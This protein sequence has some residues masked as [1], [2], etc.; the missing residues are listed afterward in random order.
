MGIKKVKNTGRPDGSI[1]EPF[2][3]TS[4]LV[5]YPNSSDMNELYAICFTP[6]KTR[7]LKWDLM[8]K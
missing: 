8:G 3:Y 5:A 1:C 7:W 4:Y 6:V 2:V